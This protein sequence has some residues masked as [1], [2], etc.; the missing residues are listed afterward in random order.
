[1]ISRREDYLDKITW[2][3]FERLLVIVMKRKWPITRL[4]RKG[5]DGG[6]DA[7]SYSVKGN[8][9]ALGQAK[10]TAKIGAPVLDATLGAAL[11]H[12]VTAAVIVTSGELTKPAKDQFEKNRVQ[13]KNIHNTQIL[14]SDCTSGNVGT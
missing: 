5:A 7:I 10:H 2:Q 3:Q 11:Q 12:G 9:I 13:G 8:S 14:R 4:T 1:V 6:A